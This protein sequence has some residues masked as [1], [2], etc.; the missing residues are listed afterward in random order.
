M[1]NLSKINYMLGQRLASRYQ[2]L[3]KLSS[4]Q[5]HRTYLAQ[6]CQ[7]VGNLKCIIK[8]IHP[9]LSDSKTLEQ[10]RNLV[11]QETTKLAQLND[12]PQTPKLLDNFEEAQAFYLVQEWIE[13]ISLKVELSNIYH[14]SEEQVITFLQESL[15]ILQFIHEKRIIHQN[16]KPS[17]WIR[18]QSDS[19]LVLVGL[20]NIKPLGNS[21][22]ATITSENSCYI[23]PEQLRNRPQLSSDLYSLGLIAIQAL[24]G[25]NP[26]NFD[27]DEQGKILW[28]SHYKG[29]S[30]LPSILNKMISLAP[31]QRYSSSQENLAVLN[32]CFTPLQHT[33]RPTE[34]LTIAQT[35]QSN[36]V[37]T[38]LPSQIELP[39]TIITTS[40]LDTIPK[41]ELLESHLLPQQN[42]HKIVNNNSEIIVNKI[43]IEQKTAFKKILN[44]CQSTLGKKLGIGLMIGLIFLIIYKFLEMRE[45][46]QI[47]NVINQIELL[48]NDG[49]Y[50]KCIVQTNSVE[51]IQINVPI[52]KRLELESKC[53]LG[54][55]SQ[56]AAQFHYDEALAIAVKISPNSPNYQQAQKYIDDWSLNVL[57][58]ANQFYQ[59]HGDLNQSLE[60][61]K[62]I[63]E[64]SPIKK[65]A[66]E[67][68]IEWRKDHQNKAGKT[69]IDLC[70]LDSNL[71]SQ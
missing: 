14:Y 6:D 17:N 12:F 61:L 69:I 42:A 36:S 56:Q 1:Q 52:E 66:I 34:I 67:Q 4:T 40:E 39:P 15:T 2:I 28:E 35:P 32:S 46:Q 58:K 10:A 25:I 18:R 30:S 48:Y 29:L 26:V 51:T 43:S 5:D 53:I 50:Q 37:V 54:S 68:S 55:A 11:Q 64:T 45:Q 19:C 31:Q 13:G 8:Q 65:K 21:L 63:P 27:E 47:A 23:A 59:D 57:E 24:T 38:T 60:M 44:F 33:Y 3:K 71:C 20:G 16:I 9:P 22:A 41:Y 70:Q 62:G 49:E 7:S